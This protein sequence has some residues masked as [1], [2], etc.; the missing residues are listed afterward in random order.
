[1]DHYFK[2]GHANESGT[3]LLRVN[4]YAWALVFTFCIK[5]FAHSP[6]DLD[7][8]SSFKLGHYPPVGGF[9]IKAQAWYSLATK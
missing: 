4:L 9:D 7:V 8:D 2:Q 5:R 1:M 3:R 6:N